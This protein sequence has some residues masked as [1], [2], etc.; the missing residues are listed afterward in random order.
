MLKLLLRG[1]DFDELETVGHAADERVDEP[2]VLVLPVPLQIPIVVESL[3][4]EVVAEVVDLGHSFFRLDPTR[5]GVFL[6]GTLEHGVIP[7]EEVLEFRDRTE[8][9]GK[10]DEPDDGKDH[11]ANE[12]TVREPIDQLDLSTVIA[13]ENPVEPDSHDGDCQQQKNDHLFASIF[14]VAKYY[15]RNN[16][17][18]IISDI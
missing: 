11:R 10:R 2:V 16:S 17:D 3:F 18:S 14:R 8:T 15:P 9:V 13:V 7:I 1:R 6:D 4:H 12:G 5:L